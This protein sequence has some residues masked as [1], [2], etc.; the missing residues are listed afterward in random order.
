VRDLCPLLWQGSVVVA[1]EAT[2]A[3]SFVLLDTSAAAFYHRG[4]G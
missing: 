2:F 3:S 4:D 1:G